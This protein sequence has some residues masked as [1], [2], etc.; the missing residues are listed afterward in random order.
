MIQKM[1]VPVDGSPQS[2]KA[3]ELACDLARKYDAE[4]E[5]FYVVERSELPEGLLHS[6]EVETGA[7]PTEPPQH[8]VNMPQQIMARVGDPKGEPLSSMALDLI[9]DYV[10][11]DLAGRFRDSG[12]QKI[13]LRVEEGSP[14]EAILAAAK[15]FKA[16]M[17]VMGSRGLG[18]LTGLLLGSVSHKVSQLA[19]CS[20]VTVK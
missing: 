5:L 1:L 13:S 18:N 8:L 10:L 20:C 17:I 12:V 9:G 19:P 15:G 4:I 6:I 7:A 16:D 3:A 14:A 11:S 2:I